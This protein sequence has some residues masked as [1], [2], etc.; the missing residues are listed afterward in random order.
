MFQIGIDSIYEFCARILTSKHINDIICVRGT[1]MC[2]GWSFRPWSTVD[3][4]F[5]RHFFRG[6]YEI[7]KYIHR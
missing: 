2:L 1:V 5:P 4:E 3:G 6:K 7:L